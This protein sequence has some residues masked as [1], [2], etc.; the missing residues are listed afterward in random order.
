MQLKRILLIIGLIFCWGNIGC[1]GFGI[2]LSK[3]EAALLS[4]PYREIVQS[5]K[6]YIRYSLD[7]R[8]EAERNYRRLEE[9]PMWR[10]SKDVSM[11][12]KKDQEKMLENLKGE[13]LET[14]FAVDGEKRYEQYRNVKNGKVQDEGPT[15]ICKNGKIY[16]Y[17]TIF[18]I[19]REFIGKVMGGNKKEG[20][21]IQKK[22]V[23]KQPNMMLNE[24]VFPG[25]IEVL[26]PQK[27]IQDK[28][29]GFSY[30]IIE[31]GQ[32]I[33]DE[34][35]YDYEEYGLKHSNTDEKG[36]K[37]VCVYFKDGVLKK[38]KVDY[39]EDLYDV[40]EFKGTVEES[41]FE[42][43]KGFKFYAAPK[44]DMDGLLNKKVLVEKY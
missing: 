33:I 21:V 43:P 15:T 9:D 41:L 18:V 30:E 10:K 27:N 2:E 25:I 35:T 26:L 14:I 7:K 5:G 39:S 1:F 36:I 44:N 28:Y 37:R 42:I 32:K 24:P 23:L 38:F 13:I 3:V 6:W 19:G 40:I 20:L 8:K 12:T 31:K 34:I 17:G 16:K 22:D 29:Y 11:M 4:D